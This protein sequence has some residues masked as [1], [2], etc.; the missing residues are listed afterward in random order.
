VLGLFRGAACALVMIA[1]F[2]LPAVS[3]FADEHSKVVCDTTTGNCLVIVVDDGAGGTPAERPITPD[4]GQPECR[5]SSGPVPC[6]DPDYGWFNQADGCYYRKADPQPARSDPAWEDHYPDGAIYVATCLGTPGTGGGYVWWPGPP[7]GFG[8]ATASLAQL[9][10]QAVRRMQLL[11]PDIGIVPEPGKVGLVGL[12]VWMWTEV[13]PR[14][15]GPISITASVP[16]LSVTAT[17][18]AE[19]ISWRM[20]DGHTVVCRG[21]GTPYADRFGGRSSPDCGHTYTRTSARNPGGAYTVTAT[22]TWRVIWAGGRQRGE[23]TIYR[24]TTTRVRIGEV[25]VLVQ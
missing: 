8:G 5:T 15:W 19:Q 25:Q 4:A 13:S 14:T 1:S 6:H 23:L 24:S 11:G 22:T 7:P 16:G 3:V 2:A 17:A 20:D 9:A 21:P 18:N 10:S 12:P